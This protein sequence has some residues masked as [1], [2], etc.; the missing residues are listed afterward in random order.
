MAI[1]GAPVESANSSQD[2]FEAAW[3]KAVPQTVRL[4]YW[5][6]PSTQKLVLSHSMS[7]EQAAGIFRCYNSMTQ[8]WLGNR[9]YHVS[10]LLTGP[11]DLP[12]LELQLTEERWLYSVRDGHLRLS[13]HP[14][15]GKE[16]S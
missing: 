7:R 15:E 12:E 10:A 13:V 1:F 16:G 6:R 14:M 8:V 9:W 2:A 5:K 11:T 4:P 3:A